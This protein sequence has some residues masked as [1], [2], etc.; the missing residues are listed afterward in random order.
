[1]ITF[2][3][4]TSQ[5]ATFEV[6]PPYEVNSWTGREMR[7]AER[8]LGGTLDGAGFYSTTSLVLA[9]GVARAVPGYT[10]ESADAELTLG[11]VREI[12]DQIN[13]RETAERAAAAEEALAAAPVEGEVLSPTSAGSEA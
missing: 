9:I 7:A 13:Q 10:V 2:T 5:G 4:R 12:L 11:R 8:L 3:W 1:M 6:E